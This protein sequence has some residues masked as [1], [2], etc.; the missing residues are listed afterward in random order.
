[1][2]RINIGCGPITMKK[3]YPFRHTAVVGITCLYVTFADD[4]SYTITYYGPTLHPDV[5]K[6]CGVWATCFM[7]HV[8]LQEFLNKT[9]SKS[10]Y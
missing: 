9:V 2:F 1:M 7:N 8:S 6:L 10:E 3:F 5:L 4:G